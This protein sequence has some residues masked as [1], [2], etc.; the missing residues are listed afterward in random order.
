MK[1][2]ESENNGPVFQASKKVSDKL[3]IL[4]PYATYCDQLEIFKVFAATKTFKRLLD[5][6]AG[7]SDAVRDIYDPRQFF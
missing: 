1:P 2:Q 3:G 6:Q 5:A 4:S 7:N